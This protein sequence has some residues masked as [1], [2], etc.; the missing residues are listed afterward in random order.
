MG[1]VR[2]DFSSEYPGIL[3]PLMAGITASGFDVIFAPKPNKIL[4]FE[5]YLHPPGVHIPAG[6]SDFGRASPISFAL[7]SRGFGSA[8][9]WI[10]TMVTIYTID[11]LSGAWPSPIRPPASPSTAQRSDGSSR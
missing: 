7:S 8:V 10:V 1:M 9:T 11:A 5:A 2:D 4:R 6:P 3:F